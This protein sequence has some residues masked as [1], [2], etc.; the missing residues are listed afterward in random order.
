MYWRFHS[1]AILLGSEYYVAHSFVLL[2]SGIPQL[3]LGTSLDG[4]CKYRTGIFLQVYFFF[5]VR[6]PILA[7][8]CV[9]IQSR[10]SPGVMKQSFNE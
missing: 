5:P 4:I 1:V 3:G 9:I 2:L 8:R 7:I 6:Q 10:S